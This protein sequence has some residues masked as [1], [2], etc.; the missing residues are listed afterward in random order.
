M[1]EW[2][3]GTFTS[4]PSDSIEAAIT[5][6]QV[7]VNTVY[8]IL[9]NL[10]YL[11]GKKVVTLPKGNGG[12]WGSEAWC[13]I[14]STRCWL[15]HCVLEF[16]RLERVRRIREKKPEGKAEEERQVRKNWWKAVVGN[17]AYTPLAVS[18]PKERRRRKG[19]G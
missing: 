6:A 15:A 10:A 13:W 19:V 9:E 7:A 5:Y 2:G 12:K 11:N 3:Y 18:F 16:A 14:W 4:P 17:A 8:Q 1:Y